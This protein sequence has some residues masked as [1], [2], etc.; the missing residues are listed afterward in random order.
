MFSVQV[1]VQVPVQVQEQ[2]QVPV[3]VPVQ[4]YL[5]PTKQLRVIYQPFWL[6]LSTPVPTLV[7]MVPCF[8]LCNPAP[9]DL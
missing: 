3:P 5:L 8:R 7:N 2:V 1:Q 9:L 6:Q 4:P